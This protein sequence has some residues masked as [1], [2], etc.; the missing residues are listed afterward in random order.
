MKLLCRTL[1][2][3]LYGKVALSRFPAYPYLCSR[4]T[5]M[6]FFLFP[7]RISQSYIKPDPPSK[8]ICLKLVSLQHSLSHAC[9]TC[10]R[11]RQCYLLSRQWCPSLRWCSYLHD[12]DIDPWNWLSRMCVVSRNY[13]TRGAR[14]TCVEYVSRR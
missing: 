3:W 14:C 13:I 12:G 5:L 2:H 4:Q 9:W 6:W 11:T 8:L 10:R 1:I 7:E